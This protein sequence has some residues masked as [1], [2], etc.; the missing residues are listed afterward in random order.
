MNVHTWILNMCRIFAADET[1]FPPALL[2]TVNRLQCVQQKNKTKK[3]VTSYGSMNIDKCILPPPP[4]NHNAH[5]TVN[6]HT[7]AHTHTCIYTH[8]R[9]HT[10]QMSNQPDGSR[11]EWHYGRSV[12]IKTQVVNQMKRFS[13][14]V[15]Q[16]V[17]KIF[18][19]SVTTEH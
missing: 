8:A 5:T 10:S 11:S 18:V 4:P 16:T 13:K 6:T 1:I 3:H 2:V 15:V 14:L 12:C 9:T 19:N 17:Y 7:H